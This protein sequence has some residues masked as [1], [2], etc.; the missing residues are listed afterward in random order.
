MRAAG[1]E[2]S[3]SVKNKIDSNVPPELSER[4]LAARKRRGVT[5]TDT[6]V[7]TGQ[8]RNSITYVV[9]NN[10]EREEPGT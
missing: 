1:M 6:L 4:T 10:N 2:A 5:R 7:D 9:V 8:F 3:A